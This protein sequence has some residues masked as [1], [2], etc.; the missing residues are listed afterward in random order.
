MAIRL[1]NFHPRP[2][3]KA[4]NI[5]HDF[6]IPALSLSVQY[7]RV[8]GY[9]RSS[10]LAHGDTQDGYVHE[11]WPVFTDEQGNRL[12]IAGSLN[13]SRTALVLN[14]E[15]IDLH[16][17]WWNDL[18]KRRTDDASDG[19]DALWQNKTLHLSVLPLPEAVR[20]RLIQ[21]GKEVKALI[22]IDGSLE[23]LKPIGLIEPILLWL[24]TKTGKFSTPSSARLTDLPD[25]F[26]PIFRNIIDA[27]KWPRR[28]FIF[29]A[30]AVDDLDCRRKTYF[31]LPLSAQHAGRPF[32]QPLS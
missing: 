24:P 21:M 23:F 19:F 14:A 12:C 13:E 3:G 28:R 7:D 17:H 29:T 11:K 9:S 26:K 31:L 4:V 27:V 32:F 6:Y 30:A 5:L 15:N 18:E 10:S 22:K 1:Q 25:D 16:A 20:Q 8:A 2:G